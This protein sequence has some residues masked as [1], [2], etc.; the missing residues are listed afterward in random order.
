MSGNNSDRR[1]YTRF[2]VVDGAFA[3]IANTPFI[4]Q[5]ISEGGMALNSVV[6]DDSPPEEMLLDMFL[7][8]ENLFLENIPVRLVRFQKNISLSPFSTTHSKCF[9]LQFGE[10]TEQQKTRLDHF[11]ARSSS[12]Q[13]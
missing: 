4:I 11:I 12:A 3:F 9:G 2:K 10:L 6:Y 8:D 5:N 13:A 7:K 1:A